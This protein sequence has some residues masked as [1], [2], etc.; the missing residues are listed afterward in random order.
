MIPTCAGL[1]AAGHGFGAV[2]ATAFGLLAHVAAV[3]DVRL[4][5]QA[6]SPESEWISERLLARERQR[7]RTPTRRAVV[8]TDGRRV[9]IEVELTVKSQR[10]MTAILDELTGRFD[11]VALLLRPGAAPPAH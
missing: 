1:R 8:I 10:R 11:A 3:N 6:R 2:A 9:A 7:G 4:H 5:V